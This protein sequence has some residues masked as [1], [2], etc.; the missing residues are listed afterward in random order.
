MASTA[1]TTLNPLIRDRGVVDCVLQVFTS[2]SEHELSLVTIRGP[3]SKHD[4]GVQNH[5]GITNVS[6]AHRFACNSN[7]AGV[8]YW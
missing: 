5:P 3:A 7:P 6:F 4:R 8:C 2:A 1:S